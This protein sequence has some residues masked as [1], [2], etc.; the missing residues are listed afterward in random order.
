DVG[1]AAHVTDAAERELELVALAGEVEHFLLG[2]AVRLAR[3]LLFERLEALDRAR[4]GLPVGEHAAQPA[5]VD[6][7]LVRTASC[8]GD[9]LL[10]LALS[11]DEQD[12]AA[13]GDGR[14]HELKRAREERNGLG[15]IDD[16]DAVAV[17]KDVRLH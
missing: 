12:L 11:A 3:K 4:D 17:A 7:M 8:L 1:N 10:R 16:V 15:E 14:V 9:R 2:E 5:M 13:G 6:E